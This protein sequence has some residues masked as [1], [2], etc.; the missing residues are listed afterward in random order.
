MIKPR[1]TGVH[2]GLLSV[3]EMV[4]NGHDVH[5]TQKHGGYAVHRESG[6]VTEFTRREGVYELVVNIEKYENVKKLSMRAAELALAEKSA[7]HSCCPKE[8]HQ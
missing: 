6:E 8:R 7:Y 4:D 3:S 1:I 5:F 2:K